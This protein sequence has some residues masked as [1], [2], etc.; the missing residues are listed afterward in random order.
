[1][2]HPVHD[3]DVASGRHRD[4]DTDTASIPHPTR[5]LRKTW[6]VTA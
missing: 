6:R 4:E 2:K 3:Y 5:L 1:M